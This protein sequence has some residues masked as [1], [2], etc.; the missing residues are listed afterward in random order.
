MKV[1]PSIDDRYIR[2]LLDDE[3]IPVI[4]EEEKIGDDSAVK[5][6][7]PQASH[8]EEDG[9]LAP[10]K[11][12]LAHLQGVPQGLTHRALGMTHEQHVPS[13]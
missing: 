3:T 8:E 12:T 11:E 2:S 4:E 6:K 10:R 5:K 7:A 1:S 9:A 13:F